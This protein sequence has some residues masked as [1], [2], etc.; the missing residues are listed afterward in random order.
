MLQRRLDPT[1]LR[2]SVHRLIH[3]TTGEG[4]F[5]YSK[6]GL[7]EDTKILRIEFFLL[8]ANVGRLRKTNIHPLLCKYCNIAG[9]SC[10]IFTLFYKILM[11][12]L[13]YCFTFHTYCTFMDRTGLET[14]MFVLFVREISQYREIS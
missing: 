7:F 10:H 12:L 6:S 4:G 14:K 13:F 8:L 1:H 11:S 9:A 5:Q 3:Y 2:V